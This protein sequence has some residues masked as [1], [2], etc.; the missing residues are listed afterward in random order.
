LR[1]LGDFLK[2]RRVK[3]AR[4]IALAAPMNANLSYLKNKFFG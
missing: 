3:K 4:K 2:Q 1:A